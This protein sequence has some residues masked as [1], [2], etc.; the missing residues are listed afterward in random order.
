M[1]LITGDSSLGRNRVGR[2][3][4]SQSRVTRL[5]SCHSHGWNWFPLFCGFTG[6]RSRSVRARIVNNYC[7][8]AYACSRFREW[9]RR[10][11]VRPGILEGNPVHEEC[12]RIAAMIDP[13]FAIN[14]VVDE[15]GRAIQI[16]AGHWRHAHRAA[17]SFYLR[18]HSTSIACRRKTIIVSCGGSPYDINLIQAHKALDMA[19]LACEPGGTIILLAECS[20]GLGRADFLKWFT[21]EDSAALERRLQDAYEVNGQ[22]AGR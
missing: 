14:A 12:E 3:C 9:W 5:F 21:S 10:E 18:E 11:K 8:N 7:R 13:T 22:T 17:C 16:F 2:L 6:G 20:D 19:A 4:R 1:P 15:R